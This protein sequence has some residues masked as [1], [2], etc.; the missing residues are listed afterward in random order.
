M[1]GGGKGWER[2]VCGMLCEML[3][4]VSVIGRVCMR[5]CNLEQG[6]RTC[7]TRDRAKRFNGNGEY[8]RGYR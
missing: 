7:L 8:L 3:A 4:F 5:V 1:W 6:I 2:G